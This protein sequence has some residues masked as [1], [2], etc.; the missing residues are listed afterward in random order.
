MVGSALEAPVCAPQAGRSPFGAEPPA[1]DSVNV[2]LVD[3]QPDNLLAMEAVLSGL[4]ANLVKASSGF[5]AL[6]CLLQ[7]EVALIIMDVRMPEM[8]GFEAA[9]MIRQRER[10][11]HTPIVFLTAVATDDLEMFRGYAVGAVDYLSKP[12]V[13]QI[14]RSKVEAFVEIFRKTEAI[15]RQSEV[16]RLLEQQQHERELAE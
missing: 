11:R 15:K 13:P 9:A 3:D 14:L 5:E 10:T 12:I 1:P 7:K 6:R 2:L 16:L 4:N 8:D